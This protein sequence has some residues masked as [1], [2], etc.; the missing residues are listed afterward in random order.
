[1]GV[2]GTCRCVR[3]AHPSSWGA[4][5][6]QHRSLRVTRRASRPRTPSLGGR[7]PFLCHT[8]V[9][10]R[11]HT[12]TWDPVSGS[13]NKVSFDT[14]LPES[15]VSSCFC[16]VWAG[17]RSHNRDRT[18]LYRKFAD[19]ALASVSRGTWRPLRLPAPVGL[20]ASPKL[21]LCLEAPHLFWVPLAF[22]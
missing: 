14:T 22:S 7:L 21:P 15:T 17:L 6:D 18:A 11:L 10:E 12:L 19:R 1:M 4:V 2:G 20:S 9:F 5:C 3:P 16:A 13:V 8:L